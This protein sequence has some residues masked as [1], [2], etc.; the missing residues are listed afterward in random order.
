LELGNDVLKIYFGSDSLK[1]ISTGYNNYLGIKVCF[2][3]GECIYNTYS[4]NSFVSDGYV[5]NNS[6]SISAPYNFSGVIKYK[7]DGFLSRREMM[8]LLT[9]IYAS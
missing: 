6:I 9:L 4:V 5:T 8:A 1:D 7:L 3:D 2:E